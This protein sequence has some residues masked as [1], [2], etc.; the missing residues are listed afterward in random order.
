VL[1]NRVK[2]QVAWIRSQSADSLIILAVMIV[3]A[4]IMLPLVVGIIVWIYTSR[5]SKTIGKKLS[6]KPKK[7]KFKP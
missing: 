2:A 3:M 7:M 6:A 5:L 1:I 4:I